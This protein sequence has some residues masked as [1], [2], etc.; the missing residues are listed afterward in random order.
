MASTL[1]VMC[2]SMSDMDNDSVCSQTMLRLSVSSTESYL[3]FFLLFD[4]LLDIVVCHIFELGKVI[5]KRSHRCRNQPR[6]PQFRGLVNVFDGCCCP[7]V[8]LSRW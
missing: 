2:Q 7:T 8:T 5:R 4:E 1:E 6:T 3:R